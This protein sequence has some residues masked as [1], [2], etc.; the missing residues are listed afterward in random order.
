MACLLIDWGVGSG[1]WSFCVIARNIQLNFTFI[2]KL[3]EM[4][5]GGRGDEW[6]TQWR[7]CWGSMRIGVQSP[8]S[9][10]SSYI[11]IEHLQGQ[12]CVL[13]A[14]EMAI[15]K[16]DKIPILISVIVYAGTTQRSGASSCSCLL[17]LLPKTLLFSLWVWYIHYALKK[18]KIK[19]PTMWFSWFCTRFV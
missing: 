19:E 1:Y 10:H 11:F 2:W 13:S 17:L 3:G 9:F 14:K 4:W 5:P 18:K 15:N 7:V 12:S 6:L 16:T 8:P